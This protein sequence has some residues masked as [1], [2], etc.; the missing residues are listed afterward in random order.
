L[1]EGRVLAGEYPGALDKGET[2]TKLRRLREAGVSTFID[3]TH[4][5]ELEP[6]EA[7][8]AS[9]DDGACLHHRMPI[10]DL[11]V[12]TVDEMHRILDL[13]DAE[14]HRGRMVYVHCW[15]GV[16]RTGTVVGCYLVRM[17]AAGEV[18]LERLPRSGRLWRS[19][20]A[21]PG[22]RKRRRSAHL[23]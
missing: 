10:R 12:P 2:E 8:L 3:L 23:F 16:G 7:L 20:I 14:L 1:I 21:A 18:A 19:A 15:G 6:Y 17:G 11:D 22:R 4:A 5:G 9:V 13:I